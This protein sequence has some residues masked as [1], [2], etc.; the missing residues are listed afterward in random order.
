MD[1]TALKDLSPN[2]FRAKIMV[3]FA[4]VW[5]FRSL[6]KTAL[7]TID[8]VVVDEQKSTM[9]GL[10]PG[11]RWDQFKD[12]IKEGFV[13]IVEKFD[14]TRP[15][16]SYRSVDNPLRICFTWRTKLTEVVAPP[17]NFPMF[18]YTALPLNML[19]HRV[20][21]NTTLSDVVGLVNKVTTIFP[22]SGK[23]KSHKRQV[24]I[25]DGRYRFIARAIDTNSTDSEDA[26]FVDLYFFGPQG[27]AAVGQKALSLLT[28]VRGQPNTLPEDLLAIVGKEFNVVVTPRRE[29]LDSYHMHL[30]APSGS[31]ARTKHKN[32]TTAKNPKTK[33]GLHFSD[34]D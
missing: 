27:E 9:K 20:D 26:K 12:L 19:S 1:Y 30:Q 22:P 28:S 7:Y 5:E 32:S 25:T 21:N 29:S 15:K 2:S 31:S 10:I 24:Y 4:R 3:R 13:Y 23:A 11:N 14:L 16:K 17:E 8:F 18:A 34:G 6:D 33:K